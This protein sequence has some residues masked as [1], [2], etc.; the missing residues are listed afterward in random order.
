M[1]RPILAAAILAVA[2]GL[3]GCS[4]N[5]VAPA[6]DPPITQAPAPTHATDAGFGSKVIFPTGVSVAL[7]YVGTVATSPSAAGGVNGRMSVFT[8]TVTNGSKAPISGALLSFPT[9]TYGAQG[10]QADP[11]F[12]NA[13]GVGGTMST[14][15]P[16]ET[17]TVKI[18]FGFPTNGAP[19]PARLEFR[20]PDF[21]SAPAIFKGQV[22]P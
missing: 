6:V 19:V 3:T 1:R 5:T 21:T 12:D 7:S 10:A 8:V 15:N 22:A 4:G 18:A 14:I 11:V 2:A 17:Q 16:G 20:A 13:S 9:A